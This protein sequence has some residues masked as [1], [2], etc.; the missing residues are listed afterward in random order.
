M[1]IDEAM[2]ADRIL[3][4]LE[5]KYDKY[6]RQMLCGKQILFSLEC[7]VKSQENGNF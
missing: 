3:N 1:K 4:L 2:Y 5:K 6:R 7:S